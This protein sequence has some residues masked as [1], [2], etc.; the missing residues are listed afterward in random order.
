MSRENVE[1]VRAGMEAWI[2]HDIDSMR[3][4]YAI[5]V[6]TWPPA[7]WAEAGPFVGRD[8][9]I[10]QWALMRETWDSNEVELHTDYVDFRD[11][12]LVRMTWR[13]RDGSEAV[14]G[15]ATGVFT[16]RDG[17]VRVAEF[18]WDHMEARR[19]LGLAE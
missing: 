14:D 11:R 2:A 15:E 6:V 19:I 5:D 9:V 1:I 16:I 4:T 8:T 18:Y 13:P 7:G 12:V 10:G 17:Q 3:E